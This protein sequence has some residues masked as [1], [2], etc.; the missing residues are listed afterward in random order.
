MRARNV[1]S[2]AAIAVA[3]SG[4]AACG[5]HH[6]AGTASPSKTHSSS[7]APT[8]AP[9]NPPTSSRQPVVVKLPGKTRTVQLVVGQ[10]L[11]VQFTTGVSATPKPSSCPQPGGSDVVRQLCSK[12]DDLSYQAVAPGTSSMVFTVKPKCTTGAVCPDWVQQAH[13]SVHVAKS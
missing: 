8:Q 13:I 1:L 5:S 9:S 2:I 7:S 4:L 6:E 3:T 11:T 12:N 10:K